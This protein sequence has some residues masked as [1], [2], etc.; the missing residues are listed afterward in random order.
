MVYSYLLY[1]QRPPFSIC[2]RLFIFFHFKNISILL[3]FQFSFPVPLVLQRQFFKQIR[4][5]IHYIHQYSRWK[6]SKFDRKPQIAP[7]TEKKKHTR[8]MIRYS[9]SAPFNRYI[10]TTQI[11]ISHLEIPSPAACTAGRSPASA[12][13]MPQRTSCTNH[14]SNFLPVPYPA[15]VYACGNHPAAHMTLEFVPSEY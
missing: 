12:A 13:D 11:A 15:V 8:I 14:R 7:T 9:I 5:S 4:S 2:I 3:Q 6:L 1:T 10:W